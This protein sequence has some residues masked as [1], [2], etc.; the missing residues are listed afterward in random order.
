MEE[1]QDS[2]APTERFLDLFEQRYATFIIGAVALLIVVPPLVFGVDF[3][4]N[5]YRAMVLM[6]V[7]S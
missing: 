5:F 4:E 3:S 2:K 1:A 7:A 6:T